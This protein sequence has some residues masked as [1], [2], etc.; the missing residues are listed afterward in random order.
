MFLHLCKLDYVGHNK[1]NQTLNVV[2]LCYTMNDLK[3]VILGD[4]SLCVDTP[5]ELFDKFNELNVNLPDD[6]TKWTPQICSTFLLS[7]SSDL[8]KR[9]TSDKNLLC[10][11][12]PLLLEKYYN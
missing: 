4:D 1:V 9:I 2:K 7:L 12:C 8:S 3:Q 5:D 11:I 6:V 10:L